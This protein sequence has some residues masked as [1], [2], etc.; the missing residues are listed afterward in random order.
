M[1]RDMRSEKKIMNVLLD[2]LGGEKMYLSQIAQTS[3]ASV[4]TCHQILEKKVHDKEIEKVKIGN[5]SVYFL[6]QNDPLVSQVKVVRT[7]ELLKPLLDK[8]Q[9]VSQK[10]I[11]FGSAAQGRDLTESDFDLFIQTNEKREVQWLIRESKIGRKIQ[12]VIKSFLELM[13]LKKKDPVFYEEINKGKVLWEE[14]HE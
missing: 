6:D 8:L 13:E 4:S 2:N 11:L 12:P 1:K 10:I 9:R 5:L 14:R 7:I 3:G